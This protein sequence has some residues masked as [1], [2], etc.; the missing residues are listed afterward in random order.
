[1]IVDPVP[2]IQ[3]CAFWTYITG[4]YRVRFVI[5]NVYTMYNQEYSVLYYETLPNGV[6]LTWS[7]VPNTC[8][9]I[10]SSTY[11]ISTIS[12]VRPDGTSVVIYTGL[13]IYGWPG[14]QWQTIFI[15]ET[16]TA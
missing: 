13:S 6:K 4:W 14:I 15:N 9:T 1:M 3:S 12:A 11:K 2:W 8:L 10:S 7:C 16:V 5:T